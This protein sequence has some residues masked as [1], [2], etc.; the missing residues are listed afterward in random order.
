MTNLSKIK[1][2]DNI[3]LNISETFDFIYEWLP[4]NY[5]KQC[6]RILRGK[7]KKSEE[8]IRLVKTKRINNRKIYT[9]LYRIALL[10]K[11]QIE[12]ISN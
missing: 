5:A 6:K 3:H 10:N 11:T 7:D 1:A 8:Y 12:E 9:A 4:R 2:P